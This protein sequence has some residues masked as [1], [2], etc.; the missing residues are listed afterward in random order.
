MIVMAVICTKK[1]WNDI[2]GDGPHPSVEKPSAAGQKSTTLVLGL[3]NTILTDDGV[4]IYVVRRL[5]A[6]IQELNVE[7][8]EASLGG[9]ELLELMKGF[10]RVILIDAILTGKHEVGTLIELRI[11]D[12]K[13]GSAMLRHQIGLSEALGLG[14]E[15]GMDLPERL[16]IY[17]I[18]VKDI[19]TFSE[20]CTPEIESRIPAIVEEI[21]QKEFPMVSH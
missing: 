10:H 8:K 9:L 14:R 15:L 4:G 18:E 16:R 17:G 3:G 20:S 6:K 1:G 11:E 7:V 21:V 12:L 19:L 2:V 13:G 5:K